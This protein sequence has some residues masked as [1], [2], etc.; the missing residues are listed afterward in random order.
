MPN[1]D[2]INERLTVELQKNARR[3][4]RE[5][6]RT[7]GIADSTCLER[8]RSLQDEGIITGY[9][10]EVNLDSLDRGLRAILAVRIHPKSRDAVES[11]RQFVLGLPEVLDVFVVTG[12]DDFQILVAVKDPQRLEDFVLD[13]I[14]QYPAV[15]DVRASLVYEHLRR[16]PV[17]LLKDSKN[18][19]SPG[20]PA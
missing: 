16:R 5:L 2:E 13:R 15:A 10:A 4:N 1:F 3:S 14:A 11:F 9:H 12:S 6:A 17:Q 19:R 7:L 8:V 20:Y 18:R